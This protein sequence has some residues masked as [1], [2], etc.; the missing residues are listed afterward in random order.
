MYGFSRKLALAVTHEERAAIREKQQGLCVFCYRELG[1]PYKDVLD[2]CHVTERIRRMLYEN[3]NIRLGHV[4]SMLWGN[5]MK[6][7]R[8]RLHAHLERR[9]L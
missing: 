4:E 7:R 6:G 8:G 5:D 9:T 3:C 2:H 1:G